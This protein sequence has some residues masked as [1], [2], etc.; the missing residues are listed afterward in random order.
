MTNSTTPTPACG[1][2]A[3]PDRH[4]RKGSVAEPLSPFFP[5]RPASTIRT[6]ADARAMES[7]I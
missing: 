7:I 2:L 6:Q 3:A 5:R 4:V 1:R